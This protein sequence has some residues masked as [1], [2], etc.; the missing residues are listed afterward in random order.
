MAEQI[1]SVYILLCM[2]SRPVSCLTS[3]VHRRCT[4][5]LSATRLARDSALKPSWVRHPIG[6]QPVRVADRMPK[7]L[8]ARLREYRECRYRRGLLTVGAEP[9]VSTSGGRDHQDRRRIEALLT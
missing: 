1:G 5:W 8:L 7:D 6:C 3:C 2:P 4:P 9:H